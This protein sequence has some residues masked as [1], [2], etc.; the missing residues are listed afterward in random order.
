LEEFRVPQKTS[1]SEVIYGRKRKKILFMLLL[2]EATH[3][4]MDMA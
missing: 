2:E 1:D 3:H 4:F